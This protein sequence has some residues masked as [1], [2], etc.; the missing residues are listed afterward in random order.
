MTR[1]RFFDEGIQSTVAGRAPVHPDGRPLGAEQADV[2][3]PAGL[4][5]GATRDPEVI[6]KITVIFYK[7]TFKIK[8]KA[9]IN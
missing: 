1:N 4:L 8:A 7:K 2:E 5:Q 9:E 3:P 6:R